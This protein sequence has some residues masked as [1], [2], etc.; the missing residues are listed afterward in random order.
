[1]SQPAYGTCVTFRQN[2]RDRVVIRSDLRRDVVSTGSISDRRE[3]RMQR[4]ELSMRIIALTLASGAAL[5]LTSSAASAQQ[6]FNGNWN[7]DVTTERGSCSKIYRFPMV[8]Q[9]GQVR[10]GGP[11]EIGVSVAVAANGVVEGSVGRGSVQATMA[12]RLSE[13]SGSGT[14]AGTGSLNCSG[15]WRA[16][17]NP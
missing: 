4:Q 5:A 17:R 16:E 11:L 13:R 15:Q 7:V 3:M 10:Y 9:N 12:G 6:Q 1:M 8:I 14:W 2:Q